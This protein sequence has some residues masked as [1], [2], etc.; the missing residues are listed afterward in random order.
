MYSKADTAMNKKLLPIIAA[1][2]ISLPAVALHDDSE[3]VTSLKIDRSTDRLLINMDIDAE[4]LG[5][6]SNRESWLTPVL[7]QLTGHSTVNSLRLPSV[8]VGGRNRYYQALRHGV[9]VPMYR[10]GVI[11]YAANVEWEPWMESAVLTLE[12]N[13]QGCCGA[14]KGLTVVPLDTLDF[15]PRVFRPVF[16]YIRPEAEMVKERQLSGRAF[17][18]FPVNKIEI[19][20]D[21]RSNPREL[22]VIRAT[23]DS[24]RLD[25]DVSVRSM[26]FKGY[27]SPEGP[28][29]NNVRLAK[30][31]TESLKN[32]VQS[33]YHFDPSVIHTSYEPEDWEGLRRFMETSGLENREA[34]LAV[35]DSDLAP[36]AKDQKLRR[37]FPVQYDFLLK[38]VFPGLR[39]T[40][41]TIG[42]T[43]RSYND[44]V[45]ILR[46]VYTRPQN[47]SLNEFFVAAQSV[48]QGSEAYNYIFE[49]AARMYPTDEI[50]NLNA[51]NAAMQQG[52]LDNASSYLANAGDSADAVYARGVLAG[53]R[54]DYTEALGYLHQAARLKVA[55]AVDAIDQIN[56]I[57][58][59]NARMGGTSN[60]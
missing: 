29:N 36:D 6:S 3:R 48:E 37:D 32:Y 1:L 24:V 11:P 17:I 23:I 30:G 5:R 42:Y 56:E 51:A 55:P 39:H 45:E 33:L 4:D 54:G 60:N 7:T 59:F 58:A 26:T 40:D 50:A 15:V 52:A 25:P 57:I 47:L 28:Y 19:Y 31:R 9:D 49:T 18:D 10:G 35:I 12:R 53:L 38:E 14:S 21:Y 41:Y 16:Q 46:L 13:E 8:F 44:P 27:A 43:I 22:S 34:I 20:P 2:A